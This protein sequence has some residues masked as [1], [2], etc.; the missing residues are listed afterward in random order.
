MTKTC[1][2]QMPKEF[3]VRILNRVFKK[4][5]PYTHHVAEEKSSCPMRVKCMVSENFIYLNL[6]DMVIITILHVR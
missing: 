2:L 4:P 1:P 3:G 6:N 5:L